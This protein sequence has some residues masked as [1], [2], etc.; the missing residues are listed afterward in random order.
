LERDLHDNEFVRQ[1]ETFVR[2]VARQTVAQLALECD[3]EDL[4][5]SG[6]EGL[7]EARERFDAS[8]GVPFKSFA[9]YRV[10]GSIIDGIRRMAYLPRRAYAR[11][12]AAEAVDLEGEQ[13]TEL[14]SAADAS[15]SATKDAVASLRA[16]DGIL[17]RVAAAYCVAATAESETS[18]SEASVTPEQT[19]L[20][21]EQKQR[22]L[23]ALQVLTE[24][25]RALVQG[26]YIEGRRFD[27]IARELGLSKSWASRVHTRA[28][29]RLR[30]AL[31]A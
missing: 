28:L 9:Y 7:L 22:V 29:G 12:K 26:H 25:E 15:G 17:G 24:Q 4:V 1:Y 19:V 23:D 13:Q 16:L 6:F 18:E 2:G 8:R 5:A 10:R 27:E 11:L 3:M 31:E 30:E 20:R 14:A 21:R